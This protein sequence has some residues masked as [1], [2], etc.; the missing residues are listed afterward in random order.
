[1]PVSAPEDEGD[2][3]GEFAGSHQYRKPGFVMAA[4]QEVDELPIP[5]ERNWRAALLGYRDGP[6]ITSGLS[7]GRS[8]S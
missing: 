6:S 8:N 2:P 5:L 3:D 7:V 4:D 1:M